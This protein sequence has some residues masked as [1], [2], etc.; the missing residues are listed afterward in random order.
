MIDCDNCVHG[1]VCR[2]ALKMTVNNADRCPYYA[3]QTITDDI[4]RGILATLTE[5]EDQHYS[6]GGYFKCSNC[7]Y[8][9]SFRA[10]LLLNDEKFC[11]HC[12]ARIYHPEEVDD[13][14]N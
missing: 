6:G 5:V 7:E 9:F 8:R 12:G 1:I 11:P 10:Y 14:N 3:K 4:N 13:E 2:K